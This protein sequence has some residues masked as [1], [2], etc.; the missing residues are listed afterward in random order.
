MCIS[1]HR[2]EGLSRGGGDAALGVP[3]G[4]EP[5]GRRRGFQK[6]CKNQ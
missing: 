2:K 4:G 5:L 6:T 1:T 3:G